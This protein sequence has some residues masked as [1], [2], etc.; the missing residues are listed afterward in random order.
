VLPEQGMVAG[1][2]LQAALRTE[3]VSV[4]SDEAGVF[5]A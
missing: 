3:V 2:W 5:L 1:V 4:V